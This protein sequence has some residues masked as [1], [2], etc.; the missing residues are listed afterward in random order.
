MIAFELAISIAPPTPWATRMRIN[1]RAAAVPCIQVTD[2]STEKTVNTAKPALYMRTRPTMS[3]SRPK[4]TTRTA[5]TTRYPIISQS[6]RLVL[7]GCS[8]SIPMPRKMSGR[9]ISRIDMF[10]VAINTPSVVLD[11]TTHLYPGRLTAVCARS[12]R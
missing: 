6:S 11:R 7:P 4:L 3:P 12:C 9:A 8:G 10:T 1:H 2:S 5:V